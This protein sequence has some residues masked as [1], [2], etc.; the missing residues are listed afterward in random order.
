MREQSD[1][2]LLLLVD[3]INFKLSMEENMKSLK[4]IMG[5][6]L[7]RGKGNWCVRPLGKAIGEGNIA[8]LLFYKSNL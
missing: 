6:S 2:G 4:S 1:I 3:G 5:R 8:A 7:R